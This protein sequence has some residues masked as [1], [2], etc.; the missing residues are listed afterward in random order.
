MDV[1][2]SDKQHVDAVDKVDDR[3]IKLARN[4]PPAG[5]QHHTISADW[6]AS[7]ED[8]AVR[9]TKSSSASTQGWKAG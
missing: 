2:G 8:D 7:G 9:L 6:V 3:Q 5:D 4:D 1:V